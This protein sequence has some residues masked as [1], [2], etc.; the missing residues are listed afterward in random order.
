MTEALRWRV[1]GVDLPLDAGRQDRPLGARKAPQ[2]TALAGPASL[3]V[4]ELWALI[5]QHSDRT[6]GSLGTAIRN[7]NFAG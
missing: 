5:E 3:R 6:I 4:L 2:G 1:S 7:R